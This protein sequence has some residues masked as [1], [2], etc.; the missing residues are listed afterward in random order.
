MT[1]VTEVEARLTEAADTL[2]RLPG[3]RP[4]GFKSCMP[5]PVRA[6]VEAYGYQ[7]VRVPLGPPSA[8]AISRLDEVLGWM[9]WLNEDEVRI[10]WA[11]ALGVPWKGLYK[12]LGIHR[13]TAWRKWTFALCKIAARIDG[14]DAKGQ[15]TNAA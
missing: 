10:I 6:V 7:P 2:M 4:M 15:N 11:R 8:A 1:T 13:S 3:H 12:R 14:R 5:V 9:H